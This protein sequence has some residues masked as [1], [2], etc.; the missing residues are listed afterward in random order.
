[1]SKYCTLGC[2]AKIYCQD[3][4]YDE[5]GTFVWNSRGA[6]NFI[7]GCSEVLISVILLHLL[8]VVQR[9]WFFNNIRVADDFMFFWNFWQ[10]ENEYGPMEWELGA[11][12]KSYAQWA[13]KMA[14]GLDTGVPW[15]MCKQDDAPDPI[16]SVAPGTIQH[17]LLSLLYLFLFL[18]CIILVWNEFKWS[19]MFCWEFIE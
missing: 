18:F 19:K 7:S 10:I 12:G 4:Q 15:V 16:V 2:N 13:A 3:C 14:V 8:F 11:P 6:N 5:S 1:M 9:L 17:F